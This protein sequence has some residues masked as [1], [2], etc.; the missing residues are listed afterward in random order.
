MKTAKGLAEYCRR[1]LGRPYWWGTFGQTAT[2]GLLAAKRQQYPGYYTASDFE[3]QLGQ[4]VH[5]CV[6]LIKGYL[7][8]DSP[9]SSPHYNPS[10]DVAVSGLY[11]RC[12]I[13]AGI[14]P[15]CRSRRGYVYSMP[16]WG[17]WGYMWAA[18]GLSRP[19]ATPTV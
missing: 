2:S 14:Y 16:L 18:E 9:D 11:A 13:S 7:W 8:S 6:G 4:R 15:L 10:Q 19:W 17:M 12:R 1:Q 5:D 3:G